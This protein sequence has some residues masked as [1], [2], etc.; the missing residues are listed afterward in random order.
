MPWTTESI[1]SLK[2]TIACL[3]I[4]NEFTFD[5]KAMESKSLT[6]A[7]C[8]FYLPKSLMKHNFLSPSKMYDTKPEN[9]LPTLYVER[10]ANQSVIRKQLAFG[11]LIIASLNVCAS[12][13]D[14]NLSTFVLN[15]SKM[16]ENDDT[17]R[18]FRWISWT[19]V[20]FSTHSWIFVTFGTI[21]G[22]CIA[23]M[24]TPAYTM[25]CKFDSDYLIL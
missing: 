7:F 20:E 11:E 22:F 21:I 6:N 17:S 13:D 1:Y 5:V 9:V 10:S 16:C 4:W 2:S 19:L 18:I 25:P 23:Q 3:Q 24:F 14:N 8:D 12:I 15:V